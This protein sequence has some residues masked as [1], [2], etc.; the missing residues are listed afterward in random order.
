MDDN[1]TGA[2][3]LDFFANRRGV[4]PGIASVCCEKGTVR[5]DMIREYGVDDHS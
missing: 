1:S 5:E 3:D 2:L 4:E